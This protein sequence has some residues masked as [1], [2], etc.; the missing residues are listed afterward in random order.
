MASLSFDDL[1]NLPS[2]DRKPAN[3]TVSFD[4]LPA[5]KRASP[6]RGAIDAGLRGVAQGVTANF[7]DEMRGLVEAGG[8]GP[9]DPSS[10]FS[11]AK[12]AL[13]Y[14]LSDPEA[15]ARYQA[16][17]TRERD[18][19]KQAGED[20]PIANT[21]GELG[22]S[23]VL[24][25]GG[26]RGATVATR[27]GNAALT[28]VGVGALS[29]AGAGEGEADTIGRAIT[30]GV[31][32]GAIGGV[33][34]PVTEMVLRGGRAA[35]GK[36]GSTIRGYRDPE[37]EAA[38]QIVSAADR[39][40]RADPQAI[41]RLTAPEF[42]DTPTANL[43][44]AGGE[45]T[46]A[47]ARQAANV[48][49]EGRTILNNSINDRFE[50]QTPRITDWMRGA[51]HYPDADAQQLAIDQ[52]E[53]AVN[54]QNYRRA[55]A[56]GDREIMTPE[57]ERL[58]GSPAVVEAMR[59]AQTSGRDRAVTMGFGAFN[60]GATVENGVVR[61]NRGANGEPTYP[62][63]Q[64]WDAVKKELDSMA[65]QAG[66]AG[67]SNAG[68]YGQLARMMRDQLD[69]Q[70]GSYQTARAGA[71]RFFG[72][73]NALEAGRNFVTRDMAP[74]EARRALAQMTPTERQL[75]QDGFVSD[76]MAK[77]N[78][79][80]DRRNVLDKINGSP[81]ARERLN[82]ALGPQRA[83]E[84]EA[85]LRVENIMDYSRRAVQGNSS[86]VR[87]LVELG[88]G[89]GTGFQLSGGDI[90]SPLAS[91]NPTNVLSAAI[92][93]GAARGKFRIDQNVAQRVA[94]ALVSR[95]PA[96]FQRGLQIAARSENLMNA[97]RHADQLFARAGGAA[98]A[99]APGVPI[100]KMDAITIRPLG[101]AD[102]PEQ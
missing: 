21:V 30:G 26:A 46:R 14:L 45:T 33:A 98:G 31:L 75:F 6:D 25:L 56:E 64:Y 57:M 65:G 86:T 80:G 50:G 42:A 35:F 27:A 87:Q 59:R 102:R 24:P 48:S 39:D 52:V 13:R 69:T 95:D 100:P 66:R 92:G 62:N 94:E 51:F 40:I 55:F 97:L 37:G 79:V 22:G 41:S 84:L 67:D 3:R 68:V 23:L 9:D 71:A 32:G 77:L 17:V 8:A 88:L 36:L 5:A 99:M 82:I 73:E 28:G 58:L 12:G 47:L 81:A 91:A 2:Q 70:V 34:A 72:A 96:V 1:P 60:P 15:L 101:G 11:L 85:R 78:E 74:N 29:G 63:L 93:A 54:R 43:M 10:L 49:P 76:Y 18:L 44:N 16:A 19:N 4:D 38:R 90:R 53:R 83:Q 89:S 20:H 61:F 7:A